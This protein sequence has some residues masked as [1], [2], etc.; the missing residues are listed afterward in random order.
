MD[1]TAPF[2]TFDDRS[3][4]RECAPRLAA[5]RAELAR[6]GLD[7]F[8][9]PHSDEYQSE[10][11]PAR[12][13][14][15]AWLTAFTGSAGAAIVLRERAAVFVDGR[16]TLQVQQQTDTKLFEPRDLVSE[17]VGAW[18]E[19]NVPKGAKLGYDPWVHTAGGVDALRISAERAGATLIACETNPIDAVW[20]DQPGPPLAKAV[21]HGLALAGESA[22]SKRTRIAEDIKKSG[23][24]AAVVTCADSICWLLNMRGGD[25]P[26]TPFVLSYAILNEDG[27]ADLFM[28]ARKSSPELQAHFGNAVRV[29]EPDEFPAALD[30]LKGKTVTADPSTCPS[31]VFD[32]L[33]RASAKVKRGADPCQLPKACKNAVEI[34]GTRKAHIRD[35]GA[36][37]SF[38][39][40]FSREAPK[41][42]LTEIDVAETLEGYRRATGALEDLSFD[43][44]SG[45]GANGAVVHYRVTQST[46]RPVRNNEMFLIDSGAQ[47]PDGTT[48]V[49]RT[50]IVGTP[51]AEMRDRFTRVL[52]GHIALGTARFPEGTPGSAL[53]AFARRPLW[54]AGLDYDHGTGHGVGSYLS[55]HEGPQNI[56][57]RPINQP[58]KPG[59]ICSNEPGFYKTGEFGI[60]IENLVVVTE[61]KDVGGE[62]P[63]MEFETITL[64]PI[65][66]NL[67][68][69]A[70][71]TDGEREWLNAYHARVRETLSPL[72]DE[73]TRGWLTRATRAI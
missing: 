63:M 17:G 36:L 69:P 12:G 13:E 38:L 2:Q 10:Y 35:G 61:P 25:T 7:G 11:L 20:K 5:L 34:E 43:S 55:V 30:A 51:T 32:R 18:I 50:L 45:A 47:Y 70:L 24:D 73:E 21:P 19:A 41:G 68:E 71:L 14:R 56:S 23:A 58:L 40:W 26:H 27:S 64:A 62:R 22:E 44:I 59:M 52:K 37:T 49:T 65:D 67:V 4:A 54:E 1:K 39:A 48:D 31:A 6:R 15:L 29:R 53:D 9:V 60:R 57:K 33:A 3:D 16:Y 42:N 46:N 72:V 66:L 28:D 8:I